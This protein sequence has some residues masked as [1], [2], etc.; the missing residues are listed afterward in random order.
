MYLR[1]EN[2]SLSSPHRLFLFVSVSKQK[3]FRSIQPERATAA[4]QQQRLERAQFD[5][6]AEFITGFSSEK[7][8][9]NQ[10]V[11][12]QIL[13]FRLKA[14][15][16]E[17]NIKMQN[18]LKFVDLI[19]HIHVIPTFSVSVGK[20]SKMFLYLW[21]KTVLSMLV[22]LS[23]VCWNIIWIIYTFPPTDSH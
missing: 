3:M 9:Q 8:E 7:P 2:G 6:A 5:A 1:G 14:K 17:S 4:N 12:T 16:W 22:F 13:T 18:S 21:L 10:K 23:S 19:E 20:K 15:E 11:L